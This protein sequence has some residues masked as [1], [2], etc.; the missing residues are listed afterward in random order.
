MRLKDGGTLRQ[1][2]LLLYLMGLLVI[3]ELW[4]L[5]LP[6]ACRVGRRVLWTMV[7]QVPARE[8][9][10]SLLLAAA[11]AALPAR[12]VRVHRR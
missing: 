1:V 2:V 4:E 8:E 5:V 9:H 11:H 3:Q 6:H 7:V 12:Q 10:V